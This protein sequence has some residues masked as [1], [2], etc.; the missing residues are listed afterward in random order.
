MN[1]ALQRLPQ[2]GL[3]LTRPAHIPGGTFRRLFLA[4][5]SPSPNRRAS[6]NSDANVIRT[7]FQL[8]P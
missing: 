3:L 7:W 1:R 2:I 8:L 5:D 4:A 6:R